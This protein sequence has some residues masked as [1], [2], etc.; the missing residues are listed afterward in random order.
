MYCKLCKISCPSDYQYKQHINGKKHKQ[1]LKGGAPS[2]GGGGGVCFYWQKGRCFKGNACTFRHSEAETNSF[3][4]NQEDYDSHQEEYDFERDRYDFEQEECDDDDQDEYDRDRYDFEREEYDLRKDEY[5]QEDYDL[6]LDEDDSDEAAGANKKRKSDNSGMLV[7]EIVLCK[8]APEHSPSTEKKFAPIFC[9]PVTTKTKKTFPSEF[10][11]VFRRKR[12]VNLYIQNGLVVWEF[13]YDAKVICAIKENIKGRAWNPNLGLKGCWTCP[14]ESLPDAIALYEFMG[15]I[16]D[17]R[18]KKRAQEIEVCYGGTSASDAIKLGIRL[19]L[20]EEAVAENST[21]GS[22]LVT[23]LYDPHVVSALKMLSPVQRSYDPSTKEWTVDILALP[24]L[25]EHLEPLGFSPSN[26]LV[27]LANSC[28]DLQNILWGAPESP[29]SDS[30]GKD[31]AIIDLV[32]TDD[33]DD[34]PIAPVMNE[35]E[36]GQKLETAL[37]K[38]VSLVARDPTGES[39][40]VLDRS[41]CGRTAKRQRLT[42]TQLLRSARKSGNF[43]YDG[44]FGGM[45]TSFAKRHFRKSSK[46]STVIVAD[47]DCGRPWKLFGGKHVC[48]Y[49]GTFHCGACGNRWTSAYCWKGETQACRGCNKESLPVKKDQFDGRPSKNTTGGAHDSA[50]CAMCRRLGY[51]CSAL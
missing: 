49:F 1:R 11:N 6:D 46:A 25:L 36:R 10:C 32:D 35:A 28:S 26:C 5:E 38:L 24:E 39:G 13:A 8:G 3:D 18:L 17:E 29:P 16:P 37:K 22:I 34:I 44:S 23:F 43:D 7:T 45:L 20:Q 30:K 31:S 42:E 40:T 12:N 50:R 15:R 19:G 27:E 9:K 47:C 21:V 4:R 14:L 48:R 51:D 33:E 41:D 2:R